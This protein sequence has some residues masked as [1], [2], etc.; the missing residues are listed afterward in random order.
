MV[1][2]GIFHPLCVSVRLETIRMCIKMFCIFNTPL[3]HR[4]NLPRQN[5]VALCAP[6]I[7][8]MK[9]ADCQH[10]AQLLYSFSVFP[11]AV[12][13]GVLMKLF[14]GALS[15]TRTFDMVTR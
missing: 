3:Y 6:N 5:F 7:S 12:Q 1:L 4:Q 2:G 9:I 11:Q 8:T 10:V 13:V 14:Y 15:I